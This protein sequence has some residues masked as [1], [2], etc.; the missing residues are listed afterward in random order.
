MND[1]HQTKEDVMTLHRTAQVLRVHYNTAY[2]WVKE[3]GLPASK[4][5][6]VWRVRRED[7]NAWLESRKEGK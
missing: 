6:R 1:C 7:L 5:G 4:I 3:E 2:R